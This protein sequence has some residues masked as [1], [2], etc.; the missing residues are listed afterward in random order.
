[1]YNLNFTYHRFDARAATIAQ[2]K[3]QRLTS[4]CPGLKPKHIIYTF[5]NLFSSNC[6]FVLWI[7]MGKERK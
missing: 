3:R 1:M 7:G 6:I 2:W 4:C 5:F